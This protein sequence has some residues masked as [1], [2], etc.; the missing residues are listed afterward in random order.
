MFSNTL[1]NS[2]GSTFPAYNVFAPVLY[3]S[4][5]NSEE[6]AQTVSE[7]LQECFLF[8]TNTLKDVSLLAP[9]FNDVVPAVLLATTPLL[10]QVDP[11]FYSQ[12]TT[13]GDKTPLLWLRNSCESRVAFGSQVLG[14]A[15]CRVASTMWKRGCKFLT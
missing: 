1:R 7:R 6:T 11:H 8:G 15:G 3:S 12:A 4:N 5:G 10:V 9:P 14:V 13:L 2:H